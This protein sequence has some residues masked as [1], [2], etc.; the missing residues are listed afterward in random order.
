MWVG[1]QPCPNPID[2][3]APGVWGIVGVGYGHAEIPSEGQCPVAVWEVESYV[4]FFDGGNA[5]DD[6]AVFNVLVLL[7][8]RECARHRAKSPERSIGPWAP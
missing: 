6:T 2:A 3:L 5:L 1:L 4:E 7:G 8:Q